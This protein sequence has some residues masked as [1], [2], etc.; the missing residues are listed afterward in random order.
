MSSNMVAS[1][2][3]R[4]T[5][6]REQARQAEQARQVEHD[7]YGIAGRPVYVEDIGDDESD[8]HRLTFSRE[9]VL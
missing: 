1:G 9:T 7:E 5:R 2:Q 3:R 8:T 6:L 4:S